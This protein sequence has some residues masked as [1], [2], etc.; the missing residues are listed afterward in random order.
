LNIA[1]ESNFTRRCDERAKLPGIKYLPEIWKRKF[2]EI[3]RFCFVLTL[4]AG[5]VRFVRRVSHLLDEAVFSSFDG[6]WVREVGSVADGRTSALPEGDTF[7]LDPFFFT[8][9]QTLKSVPVGEALTA[10]IYFWKDGNEWR[11]TEND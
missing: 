6:S 8:D 7:P 2:K 5:K 10:K 1:T 11:L 3:L 4:T 9:Y